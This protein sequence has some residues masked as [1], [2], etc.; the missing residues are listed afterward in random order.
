MKERPI[1]FNGA[2]VRAL[3]DGSKSQTRRI[4]KGERAS[5]G[6]ESGWYLKPY[7][8]VNDRQFAKAACRCG[9]P[10]DQLWVRETWQHSN[11]HYGPADQSCAIFYRADYW[12]DPHG[13]DGEKSPEGKYR[14]WRPSIHMPRWASRITLEIVGVRVERLQDIS[15]EDAL[16]EGVSDMSALLHDEWKPLE[17]E[18]GNDCARRLRWPQRLYKQLWESI[19][20]KG[21]WDATPWVFVIEFRRLP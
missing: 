16:A 13:M 14:E 4:V 3:L 19:N 18:S 9:Q 5:R 17:G 21:S 12:D 20:G 1:L 2:M 7:G 15:Y 10:G 11:H 6:L 8:F